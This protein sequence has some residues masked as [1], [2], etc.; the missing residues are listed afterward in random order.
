MRSSLI[1]CNNGRGFF[2]ITKCV[3][4]IETTGDS[5]DAHSDGQ[6]LSHCMC[7]D[8]VWYSNVSE[9]M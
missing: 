3:D 9:M 5:K 1:F 8:V 6:F 7:S 4:I 2:F